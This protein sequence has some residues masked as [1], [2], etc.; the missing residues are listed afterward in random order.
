VTETNA[1]TPTGAPVFPPGRYGRR[2]A[3]RRRRRW[4]VA[5]LTVAAVVVGLVVALRLHQQYG[6]GPYDAELVRYSDVTDTQVVVQFRVHLPAG[7]AATCTVRARN[8]AG[9]EVGRATVRVPAGR[10]RRPLVTHRLATRERPVTGE[11][12]GC[13]PSN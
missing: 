8:R 4:V 1:T 2:R 12:Q 13:A 7:E 9:L 11:I 10:D 3:P 6:T 5:A